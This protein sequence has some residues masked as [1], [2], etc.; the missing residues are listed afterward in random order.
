MALFSI[1][2][3]VYNRM[4][5]LAA[6]LSSLL[7]QTFREFE[8][9][10]VDAGSTDGSMELLEKHAQKARLRLYR[11]ELND[12]DAARNV[13]AEQA[14]APWLV[15]F[16]AGDILLFDHLSRFADAIAKHP[17]IDLFVNAFQRM[18]GHQRLMAQETIPSGVLP[19]REALKALSHGDYIHLS[20]ACIRRDRFLALGGFPAER[21]RQEA[22][23]YF[24]LKALCELER[25]HYDDTVTSLLLLDNGTPSD[26][27]LDHVPPGGDLLPVYAG[28][29]SRLEMRYLRASINRMVLAWAVEKKR[30][31][32]SV[33]PELAALSLP[34]LRLRDGLL[35]LGLL[36]PQPYYHWLRKW[37]KKTE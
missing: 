16:N 6:S 2:V 11:S 19:R 25:I 36:V 34:G 21:Y 27:P 24:W 3:A 20:G 14:Q 29:L 13:G 15:F 22:N 5:T 35:A 12:A 31:G 10:A 30:H 28:R 7:Q 4:D 33:R 1:V 17:E 18:K 26:E 9:V 32:R 23:L 37:M 8:I